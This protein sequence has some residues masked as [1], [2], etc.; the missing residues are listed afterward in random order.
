MQKVHLNKLALLMF[1]LLGGC[2]TAPSYKKPDMDLPQHFKEAATNWKISEPNS[3]IGREDWW[4][5]FNDPTLNDL[6]SRGTNKNF[7]IQAATARYNASIAFLTAN[8]ASLYPQIG[9]S[10]GSLNN[11]QSQARPL[12]GSSQPNIYDSN[13]VSMVASYELDL[14]GRIQSTIDSASALSQAAL[15]DVRAVKLLIRTEIASTYFSILG[16]DTQ[17]N[18]IEK[19]IEAYRKQSEIVKY[20]FVEGVASGGEFYRVQTI[21]ENERIRMLSLKTKRA[22]LEHSLALLIGESAS[23][24]NLARGDISSIFLPTIPISLPSQLLERRPDISSSERKVAASNADIG[25]ANAAF[26]PSIGLS[27]QAGYQND[28]TSRLITAPN[29]FWSIGPTAFLTLFDA[30]RRDALVSQAKSRNL[31]AIALYKNTVINAIK[32]VEDILIDLNDREAAQLNVDD[33]VTFSGKN[34]RI[35]TARY[36]EGISNYLEI[37]DAFIQKSQSELTSADQSTQLLVGRVNL[38]KVLGGYWN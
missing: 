3:E 17:I 6:I 8:N 31:E 10:G 26:F 38:I 35:A 4:S 20:R 11:R 2:S 5:V 34:Y 21:V 25:I 23:N 18:L 15:S 19:S 22:T 29:Q 37:V 30:G 16:L 12:R 1:V 28:S 33:A 32:E 14:W 9:V 27:A 7:Q 24:F 36:N 13:Q